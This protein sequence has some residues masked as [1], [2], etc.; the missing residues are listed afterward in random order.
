MDADIVVQK[1]LTQQLLNDKEVE[2]LMNAASNYQ[3][4]YL[5]LEKIRL[6]NMQA[7]ELFCKLLWSCDSQKH[8][9]DVLVN[10]K[11]RF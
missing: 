2:I 4:N 6:M 9:A 7:L 1:M 3:K 10:G 11:F 5:L 8:I